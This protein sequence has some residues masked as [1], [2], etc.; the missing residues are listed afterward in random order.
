MTTTIATSTLDCGAT[1]VTEHM[2][3]VRSLA[4]TWLIPGGSARDPDSALGAAAALEEYL[5]RGAGNLDSR[6]HAD[7]IDRLGASIGVRAETFHT[8]ISATLLAPRLDEVLPLIVDM[9]LRPRFDATHLEPVQDLCIQAIEGLADEPSERIMHELRRHHAPPPINRSPLG[10]IDGIEALTIPTLRSHWAACANP[11]GSIIA[12]AGDITHPRAAN[13]LNRLLA[14]WSGATPPITWNPAITDRGYHHVQD[15]TSQVHIAIAHDSPAEPDPAAF[16][17]RIATAVLSGGMSCRLFTEVREKRSLC[18]SVWAAYA[19][20]ATFGRSI[21]YAGT[22]PERAQETL[23]VLLDQLR[24]INTPK[25]RITPDE[26]DRA[27]T[28]FKSRLVMSGES[29]SARAGALARDIHKLGRPRS[30]QEL[31]AAADAVT[32]HSLNE[33]LAQRSLGDITVITLGR[34]PLRMP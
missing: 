22:T 1:L 32:L 34:D 24:S 11:R 21:A 10:T 12:L 25:G 7:A 23:D 18:Y 6:A 4:I 17:E 16:P 20:D 31:A 30:L 13:L 14:G 29:S 15:T 9:V 19:A 3:G 2:P 8:A 33:Y 27:L 26:F 28:G 5:C